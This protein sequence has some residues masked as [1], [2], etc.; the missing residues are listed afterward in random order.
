M[1]LNSLFPA[2]MMIPPV[3]LGQ[4]KY[5]IYPSLLDKFQQLLDYEEE[6]ESAWNKDS[7][8]NY[9]ISPEDMRL[10]LEQE[11]VD[12]INRAPREPS[13][14]ADR[15]TALNEIV[16]CL[17][18]NEASPRP[19]ITIQ[20][21]RDPAK[22]GTPYAIRA[23]Y[24]GF[25]FDFDVDLCRDLAAMLK[26][27]T[28]QMMT[29]SKIMTN[30][31]PVLL[32]GYLDYWKGNTVID[33]KTTSKYTFGQYGCKWQKHMYPWSLIESGVASRVDEFTY[34]AV[35]LGKGKLIKG[36]IY[37]ETYTY[38]HGQSGGL[39]REHIERFIFWLLNNREKITDTK[40]FNKES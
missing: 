2:Q 10:R 31:G 21:L 40:I 19:D 34:L 39:L 36:K 11:L 17:I 38:N 1:Q 8:D 26:G 14:A 32:Y 35:Q 5:R 3:G 13:F 27:A 16:D 28:T 6:A 15:G 23:D 9:V 18:K 33:L 29:W 24:N 7:G 12:T 22:G 4:F 30:F 25:T 37:P 20:S